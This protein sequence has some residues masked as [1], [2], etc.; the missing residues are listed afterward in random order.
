[1]KSFIALF[2][3]E[4]DNIDFISYDMNST[5]NINNIGRIIIQ[6]IIQV[7]MAIIIVISVIIIP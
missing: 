4:R 5:R 7:V 2:P 1:M 6:G 3:L